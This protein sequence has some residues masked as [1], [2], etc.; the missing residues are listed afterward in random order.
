LFDREGSPGEDDDELEIYV[1]MV[2][3]LLGRNIRPGWGPVTGLRLN[4]RDFSVA[5]RSLTY[6]LVSL[7]STS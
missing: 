4:F 1:E 6:Y 2:E 3:E 5:H 7:F